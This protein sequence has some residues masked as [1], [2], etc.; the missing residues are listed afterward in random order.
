MYHVCVFMLVVKV[1]AFPFETIA[2]KTYSINQNM[3]RTNVKLKQNGAFPVSHY[4]AKMLRLYLYALII[5]HKSCNVLRILKTLTLQNKLQNFMTNNVF[6]TNKIKNTSTT[7]HKIKH[8]NPCRSRE[9]N[10]GHLAPKAD[11]L[12]LHHRVN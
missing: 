9:L 10:P 1:H 5:G 4:Y 12:P 11:A 8:K 7:K 2:N 6:W 3:I